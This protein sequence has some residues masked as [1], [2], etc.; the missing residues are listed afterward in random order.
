MDVRVETVILR[1]VALVAA[2]ASDPTNAPLWY[3]NIREVSWETALPLMAGTRIAFVA[4]FLGRKMEYVYQVTDFVEGRRL[5]METDGS[6]FPMR[7]TYTWEPDGDGTRMMLGNKG[8]PRG[9]AKFTAPLMEAAMKRAMTGDLA[10]L[11]SL[12]EA[13]AK[14]PHA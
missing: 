7:T 11:K 3:A 4:R 6:P 1:P 9:F 14:E 12:L 13:Q 8:E 10:K 5:V 2:F